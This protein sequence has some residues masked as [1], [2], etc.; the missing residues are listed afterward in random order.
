MT[1]WLMAR[2][3]SGQRE[4][5]RRPRAVLASPEKRGVL[6]G[7]RAARERHRRVPCAV[8]L[9]DDTRRSDDGPQSV[10]EGRGGW[11][12]RGGLR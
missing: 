2:R 8:P 9:R 12:V 11:P 4:L 3:A 5:R 7:L 6:E 1:L 10:D